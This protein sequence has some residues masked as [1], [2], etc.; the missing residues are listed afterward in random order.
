MIFD[1]RIRKAGGSIE[2]VHRTETYEFNDA[3]VLRERCRK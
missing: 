2:L 3:G 1:K